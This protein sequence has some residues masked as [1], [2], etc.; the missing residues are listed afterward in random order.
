MLQ[1]LGKL[2]TAL[3]KPL[4]PPVYDRDNYYGVEIF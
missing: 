3:Y 2:D 4:L 1:R